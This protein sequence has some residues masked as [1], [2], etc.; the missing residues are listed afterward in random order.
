MTHIKQLFNLSQSTI[1]N[2][3]EKNHWKERVADYDRFILVQKVKLEQT[4]KAKA[5]ISR[6]SEYR[7]Q[8]ESIGRSISVAAG[9]IAL[10]ANKQ[11]ELMLVADAIVD[12]EKLPSYLN[13]AAKLAEVGKQLQAGALGVDALLSALDE[14]EDA[15]EY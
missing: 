14:A 11:L 8:Q 4:N 5:H 9:R 6:L 12:P 3:A 15:A 13:A 7:V 2:M 1:R 10:I